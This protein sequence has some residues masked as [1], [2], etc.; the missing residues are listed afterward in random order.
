[1]SNRFLNARWSLKDVDG[2]REMIK[3]GHSAGDIATA[4]LTTEGEI[5]ALCH[6]N[7]FPLPRITKPGA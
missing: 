7:D 5:I 6:R 4:Y 3:R 1:M 2:I